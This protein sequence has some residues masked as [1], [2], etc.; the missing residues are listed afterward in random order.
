MSNDKRTELMETAIKLFSE[1]GYFSTSV[2]EI[3]EECGISKGSVY[4][5]FDS[6]EDLLIQVFEHNHYKM[7]QK[8][9]N[10]NLDE[11]LSAQERFRKMIIIELEGMLDNKDF[12]NV[13][14]R[15]LLFDKNKK[16]VPLM[17]RTRV[18]MINWHKHSLMQAYGEEHKDYIWDLTIIFQGIIKEFVHLMAHEKK[19]VDVERIADLIVRC[20]NTIVFNTPQ[21]EPVLTSALMKDYEE[22]DVSLAPPS[23]GEQLTK[24]FSEIEMKLKYIVMEEEKRKD[25]LSS[26]HLLEK[27]INENEPRRFLIHALLSYLG[28]VE[29]LRSQVQLIEALV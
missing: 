22:L 23:R 24:L 16:I 29:D 17:K 3:A 25:M 19:Q 27:E 10:I 6:K 26:V 7:L 5:Y 2:Q 15:S 21:T 12:F 13:L 14:S 4:K 11:S 28:Y 1:K 9:N 20:L 8:A 18:L